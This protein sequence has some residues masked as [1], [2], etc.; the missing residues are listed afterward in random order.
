MGGQAG[1]PGREVAVCFLFWV[2]LMVP[3]SNT[4]SPTG[5]TASVAELPGAALL[6]TLAVRTVK[7]QEDDGI[8]MRWRSWVPAC[9]LGLG[10][11]EKFQS[12][13]LRPASA[14]PTSR[15]SSSRS[16]CLLRNDSWGSSLCS[17]VGTSLAEGRRAGQKA[18]ELQHA[19]GPENLVSYPPVPS[20]STLGSGGCGY[21]VPSAW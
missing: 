12:L 8:P 10:L 9:L 17:S 14:R 16:I 18:L 13:I 5:G 11:Q 6:A 4:Q 7:H 19:A 20:M 21:R 3:G 2:Q 1:E 15:A